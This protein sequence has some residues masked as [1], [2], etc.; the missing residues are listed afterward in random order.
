MEEAAEID[1]DSEDSLLEAAKG[2]DAEAQQ[3]LAMLVELGLSTRSTEPDPA[4]AR[5][6]Y[7][8]AAAKGNPQAQL[9]LAEMLTKGVGGDVK[10]VE[11]AKLLAKA[12]E[13]GFSSPDQIK[14]RAQELKPVDA[15]MTKGTILVVE[16]SAVE[17]KMISGFLARLEWN[18]LLAR[19]GKEA[20]V[21][22]K[23]NPH[24]KLVLTDLHMPEMD[25][26]ALLNRLRSFTDFANT[27][28]LIMSSSSDPQSIV[29]ARKAGVNGWIVKPILK[30]KLGAEIDRIMSRLGNG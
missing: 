20:I 13:Q 3:R 12:N 11:A 6:W 24:I 9:A 30:K 19:N 8:L 29:K 15:K 21:M 1:Y 14:N 16:D 2:G 23:A 26:I 4:A 18:T 27:P 7:S 28:V 10:P 5:K 25:G 17:S 22:F